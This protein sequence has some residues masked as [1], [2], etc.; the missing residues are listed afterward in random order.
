MSNTKIRK[1]CQKPFSKIPKNFHM[2]L[3]F[4]YGKFKTLFKVSIFQEKHKYK[5]P[6]AQNFV[7]F[8]GV[9]HWCS[10]TTLFTPLPPL[11]ESYFADPQ[12]PARKLLYV[13]MFKV[14]VFSSKIFYIFL[15]IFFLL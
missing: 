5:N 8:R 11:I 14:F 12:P 4:S 2:V 10:K 6:K 13:S 15:R 1:N 7:I 9:S 3:N